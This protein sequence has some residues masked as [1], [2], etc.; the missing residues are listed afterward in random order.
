VL[1]ISSSSLPEQGGQ[2]A[3]P[4]VSSE[5]NPSVQT[6]DELYRDTTLPQEEEMPWWLLLLIT[7]GLGVLV[8]LSM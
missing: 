4:L 8:Y 7:A 1:N 5:R 2:E 3:I 6:W